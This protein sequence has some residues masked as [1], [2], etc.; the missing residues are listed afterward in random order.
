MG[1]QA[2]SKK[3]NGE[4][5]FYMGEEMFFAVWKFSFPGLSTFDERD[6][7][8]F[9][10][11][12]P[13]SGYQTEKVF[14][15]IKTHIEKKSLTFPKLYLYSD[16]DPKEQL[17]LPPSQETL[18]AYPEGEREKILKCA[19]N[20]LKNKITLKDIE[21]LLPVSSSFI[22]FLYFYTDIDQKTRL[23]LK[24]TLDGYIVQFLN[25]QLF[26]VKKNYL[27]FEKQKQV[28]F[29]KIKN[30]NSINRYGTNFVISHTTKYAQKESLEFLFVQTLYALQYLGYLKVLD[31]W[32][33]KNS[34]ES[35]TTYS[36][37]II[38]EDKLID[39]LNEGYKTENPKTHFER[40]DEKRGL[41]HFA[42]KQ[43]AISKNGKETYPLQLLQTLAKDITKTP[44]RYW[45]EDE[46]LEDWGYSD[47]EAKTLPKNRVY[48]ASVKVN[49]IIQRAIQIDDF[50]EHTTEKF[51]IN[52]KYLK[53]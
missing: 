42:G 16:A 47:E 29:E 32:Y 13:L 20:I 6:Y 3:D 28:F 44:D 33:D 31:V 21:V 14:G 23:G 49:E 1:K 50:I 38:L 39:E 10:R 30:S 34:L 9:S 15:F 24:E 46:I 5:L 17:Y 41:L 25:N 7:M 43:I 4:Y 27:V 37:N 36:A 22:N 40:L 45:F 48:F 51:R 53:N 12:S 11:L 19:D 2:K 26:V 35:T 18:N 8:D 52:P